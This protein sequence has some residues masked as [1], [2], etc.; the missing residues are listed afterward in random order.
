MQGYRERN[1]LSDIVK[2]LHTNP[3]VALLE[4]RQVGKSTLAEMI[5]EQFPDAI[6]SNF[7]PD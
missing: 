4:A 2:R 3:A 5:I 6:L 1:L 7:D